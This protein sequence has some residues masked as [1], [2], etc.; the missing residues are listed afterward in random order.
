VIG[1]GIG[2]GLIFRAEVFRKGALFL[3]WGT[4]ATAYRKHPYDG[5]VRHIQLLNER[6]AAMG[7]EFF[8]PA[9]AVALVQSMGLSSFSLPVFAQICAVMTI[10][11][12]VLVALT[13]IVLLTR[14]S[15]KTVFK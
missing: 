3:A 5:F 4:I 6:M 12:E 14:P 11:T 7:S 2:V 1:L 13:V 10:I 9:Y 8:S 15:I